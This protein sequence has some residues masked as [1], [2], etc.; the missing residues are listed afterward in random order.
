MAI[1]ALLFTGT[2]LDYSMLDRFFAH[3]EGSLMDG[4]TRDPREG[5]AL[6]QEFVAIIDLPRKWA[7][8]GWIHQEIILSKKAIAGR[9]IP[10]A[11]ILVIAALACWVLEV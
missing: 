11:K 9:G 8:K 3:D 5:A 6:K 4:L 7:T 1:K 10:K 2:S